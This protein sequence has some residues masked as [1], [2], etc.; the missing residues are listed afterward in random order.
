MSAARKSAALAA[1]MLLSVTAGNRVFAEMAAIHGEFPVSEELVFLIQYVGSDYP[2]AVRDGRVIDDA[3]YRELVGFSER[4]V[5][6]YEGI[7]PGGSARAD[8]ARLEALVSGRAATSAVR[9]LSRELASRIGDELD[10]V[11]YPAEAPDLEAGRELY[12]EDCSP[13][14]GVVGGG[15]GPSSPYLTPKPTSFREARVSLLSPHQLFNATSFGIPG[16]GMPAYRGALTPGQIWDVAFF[17]MTQRDGF[18]PK[19]PPQIIPLT[20]KEIA[21]QS[22][23]ELLRRLRVSRPGAEAAELDYYR[24]QFRG[25]ERRDASGLATAGENGLAVAELL[26][27]TFAGVASRVFPN[28]VGVSVYEKLGA[29][30]PPQDGWGQ[31][32]AEDAIYPGF[33]RARSGTG[34]LVTG[35]GDV[36]T[37]LDVLGGKDGVAKRD[38]IDVELTGNVHC[39]AR[40]IGIEPTINLAVLAIVP[41]VPVRSVAVGDSDRVQVGD[42]AIAVGDPPGAARTF[43]PGTIS[44]R[45]ERECYQEQRTSTLLQSSVSI[46]LVAFGGPLVNIRGEVI[47]LTIPDPGTFTVPSCP[48][49]RP[50]SALPINLAMTIYRALKVKESERSPWIGF[51][52]LELN[53]RL[54][55]RLKSA[56]LTGIYIDDVF[57]PSPASRAGIR[58]GDVLT[59][60]DDHPILGVP[61]FQTWLYLLGI[62]TR[63]T[64]E[65]NRDGNT[66]RKTVT[67]EERPPSATTR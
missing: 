28:V 51:S 23:E 27:H 15:D 59:K 58:S 26:A 1:W 4:I 43:A 44:A 17:V 55:G 67:I 48:S 16:T 13:C 24:A 9:E 10:V 49:P 20:L 39:R 5:G 29:E 8:L 52:V 34:F 19:V 64:L 57:T 7:L 2:A 31:G 14:H 36:L 47:G 54:R 42:W 66:L 30:A 32:A 56:P 41:P 53:A 61:D 18:D 63:V 21:A 60:M 50:V 35:D 6:M 11:P 65:L 12:R 37:C 38:V 46:D 62:D 45:A 25:P 33:R 40:V 22:D 3:E